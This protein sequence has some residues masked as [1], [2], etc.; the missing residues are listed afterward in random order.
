MD[1]HQLA[2]RTRKFAV[3]AFKLSEQFSQA[4]GAVV[5]INQLLRSSSSVAANY[6]AALRAKSTA[7]FTNKLKIVLEEAD[8]SE[9]WLTFVA[10]TGV[11]RQT[12]AI[13]NDCRKRQTN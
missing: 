5:V 6:R 3:D 7:D 11:L 8:E 13:Y 9:F 10:E 1:K 12:I 4:R 2:S